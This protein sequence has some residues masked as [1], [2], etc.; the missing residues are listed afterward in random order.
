MT[1]I[2]AYRRQLRECPDWDALLLAESGLP[3][4]RGN[5]ELAQA[6]AAEGD[7]ARFRRWLT[8]DAATA[9]ANT[10]EEFLTFCGVLGLGRLLAG[11]RRDVL[12]ELAAW[13]SD[14]RWRTREA[15]VMALQAWG[16]VD[17]EALLAEMGLW[18]QAGWFE[19]RAV[20]AGLCEPRLL[21]RREEA[22]RVLAVLDAITRQ[23]EAAP[24]RKGEGFQA[25]RKA[26]AYGWSV[27]VAAAPEPG[28][29]LME[30]WLRSPDRDVRWIMKENLTKNRLLRLDPAW[31]AQARSMLDR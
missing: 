5:L 19:Q 8:F 24:D 16:D 11:G 6:A 17:M 25:L 4:P 22:E 7:E 30:R 9:P 3:G 23:V 14:P 15:V 21:R 10:A 2:D 18:R 26:L 1:K 27:A 28:R 13:A 12:P 29:T 20:V 31:V